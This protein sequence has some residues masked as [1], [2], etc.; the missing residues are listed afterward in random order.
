MV[1]S[2]RVSQE[3]KGDILGVPGDQRR[4]QEDVRGSQGVKGDV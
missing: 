4:R 3:I 2:W 1:S